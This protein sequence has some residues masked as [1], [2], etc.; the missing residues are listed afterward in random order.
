MDFNYM[1]RRSVFSPPVN[2][3][4]TYP[5]F[6]FRAAANAQGQNAEDDKLTV[7][8]DKPASRF[9]SL[10]AD[11]AD[12]TGGPAQKK[13]ADFLNTG[14]NRDDYKPTKVNRLAA[15][16]AGVSDGVKHGG[17]AGYKTATDILDQP[18]NEAQTDY[19]TQAKKLAAGANIEEKDMGRRVKLYQDMTQAE[20]DKAKDTETNRHNLAT[21]GNSKLRAERTG[22]HYS[23]ITDPNTGHRKTTV[24]GPD[25]KTI[26][27]IDLGKGAL[28]PQE[29]IKEAGDK[30]GAAFNSTEGG[31][32]RVARAGAAARGDEARK[33]A[34]A[35][36][37][38]IQDL[39]QWKKDSGINDKYE[40]RVN[41]DGK[42]VYVNKS[43]PNDF[44]V[45]D[46]DTGKMSDA[47]KQ[48]A[49]IEL[50]QTAPPA[51]N[52]DTKLTRDSNGR[53]IEAKTTVTHGEDKVKVT[54]PDGKTGTMSKAEAD[55]AVKHGWKVVK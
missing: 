45:T 13:Y 4:E 42:L 54:S 48:K 38:N 22:L 50:K 47:D 55:E 53:V 18:Y 20:R 24:I 49:K 34:D 16:L 1:R 44:H 52:K 40:G 31:R 36:F 35:K 25:A 29:Q 41:K 19:D 17:G 33:T 39:L 21:E 14:P 51:S 5:P 6:D 9:S 27:N 7:P 30:A 3:A 8:Q 11:L 26:G 46:I 12:E 43:D 28:T 37:S 2:P 32:I 10:Y 23:D 15:I